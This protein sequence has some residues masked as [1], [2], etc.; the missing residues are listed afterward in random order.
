ML[1]PFTWIKRDLEYNKWVWI[2][3]WRIAGSRWFIFRD[4]PDHVLKRIRKNLSSSNSSSELGK[5][6]AEQ[7][8]QE[9]ALR[10][11]NE[12]RQPAKEN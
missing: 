4:C 2:I 11:R 7:I 6:L 3:A 8:D 9:F 1:N 12:E 10:A 5:N